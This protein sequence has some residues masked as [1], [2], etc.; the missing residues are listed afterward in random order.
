MAAYRQT[1]SFPRRGRSDADPLAGVGI[2]AVRDAVQL[3][4]VAP[5]RIRNWLRGYPA[6]RESPPALSGQHAAL[7]GVLA[8]GFLDLIEVRFI[9][10]FLAHGVGWAT[11]RKAAARAAEVRSVDH[12]FAMKCRTDGRTIF[13][14][15]ADETGDQRLFDLVDNQYALLKV[16]EPIL[17]EG[18]EYDE[19]GMAR[20]WH[21]LPRDCPGVVLD[22]ERS[23]G[24]PILADAGI[25]T[26]AL[27][28]A[29]AA[30]GD[31]RRVAAWYEVDSADVTAAVDFELR[32]ER[33]DAA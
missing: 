29:F 28:Q 19:E 10:H 24:R 14:E 32:L 21:P 7:D 11:I 2:Y 3:T 31:A 6:T 4:G 5:R 13:A 1:S 20:R 25:P 12:P 8:L 15:V 16:L 27:Y 18:I 33:R 17:E 30:E 26:A 22:P 23:F 9:S